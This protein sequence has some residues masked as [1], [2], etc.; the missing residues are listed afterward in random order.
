MAGKMAQWIK[1]LL[2]RHE[3]LSSDAHHLYKKPDMQ[4]AQATPAW[5][6]ETGRSLELNDSQ[7]SLTH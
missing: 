2:D 5:W 6:K 3:N 1:Y 4:H 7:A